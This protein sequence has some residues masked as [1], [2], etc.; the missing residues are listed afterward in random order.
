MGVKRQNALVAV[1]RATGSAFEA[2]TRDYQNY[3][4][5]S[6]S[7]MLPWLQTLGIAWEVIPGK[8]RP[9]GDIMVDLSKKFQT[10]SSAQASFIGSKFGMD[11]GLIALLQTGPGNVQKTLDEMAK[12]G[13]ASAA[14]C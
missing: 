10:M 4:I 1:R 9:M 14:L 5:T 12:L 6:Q 3:K 2:M 7:E 8:M 11:N 13:L